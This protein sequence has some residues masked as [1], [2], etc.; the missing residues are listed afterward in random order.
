MDRSLDEIVAD[1]QR[2][3]QVIESLPILICSITSWSLLAVLS[4]I[5][6]FT[7]DRLMLYE[8][9]LEAMLRAYIL[10]NKQNDVGSES[11]TSNI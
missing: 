7:F 9:L 11:T 1:E 5:L 3:N 2:G 8:R 10:N 6:L 4:S